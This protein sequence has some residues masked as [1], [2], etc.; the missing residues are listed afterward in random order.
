MDLDSTLSSVDVSFQRELNKKKSKERIQILINIS[1]KSFVMDIDLDTALSKAAI[2]YPDGNRAFEREL[3]KLK[4]LEESGLR[5]GISQISN[6][7]ATA[8]NKYISD[9]YDATKKSTYLIYDNLYGLAMCM[10]LPTGKFR[11]LDKNERFDFVVMGQTLD[12]EKGYIFEVD[13]D[14]PMNLHSDYPLAP[15]TKIITDEMLPPFS[16]ILC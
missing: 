6:R 13:L 10:S 16:R 7:L 15:E 9:T 5:G 14:Y 1:F 2:T 3:N 11:F 8:N 4:Q 12:A